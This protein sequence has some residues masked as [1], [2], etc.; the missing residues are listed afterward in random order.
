MST[1]RFFHTAAD[2]AVI[3]WFAVITVL[4]RRGWR[5][6]ALGAVLGVAPSTIHGW[7]QGAEPKY[8]E[9]KKLLTLWRRVMC[10]AREETRRGEAREEAREGEGGEEEVWNAGAVAVPT[11]RRG[12]WRG[13]HG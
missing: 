9:G 4:S 1:R 13:Y 8:S 10:E 6:R 3:D 2:E 12:D 7:K 5:Q 11:L